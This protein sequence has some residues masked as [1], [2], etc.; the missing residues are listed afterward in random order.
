MLLLK[1]DIIKKRQVDK[2]ISQMEF[3]NNED[4]NREYKVKVICNSTIYIRKLES[5][6]PDLY[7]L[8]LWKDY[9]KKENT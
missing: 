9:L 5:Y 7:Y 4:E 8:V 1:Q 2:V 3:D 6:L